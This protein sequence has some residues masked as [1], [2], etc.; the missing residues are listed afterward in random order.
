MKSTHFLNANKSLSISAPAPV[1]L[2]KNSLKTNGYGNKGGER[3]RL[4]TVINDQFNCNRFGVSLRTLSVINDQFNCNRFG[5]YLRML[6]VINDQFNCN[7][8]GV[9]LRMLSVINAGERPY[10]DFP[11]RRHNNARESRES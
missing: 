6:S 1:C 3:P 11:E 4:L 5:V 7:R 9:Y 10:R 8:F 2:R